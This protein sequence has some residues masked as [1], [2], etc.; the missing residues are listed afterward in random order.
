MSQS[1]RG[2]STTW[3]TDTLFVKEKSLVG[4]ICAQMFTDAEGFVYVHLMKLKSLTGEALNK[5]TLDVGVHNCIISDGTKE[6]SGDNTDFVK[7]NEA[8]SH[9]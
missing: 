6:E 8:L 7:N 2:L 1:L 9:R 4:N 3:Y 5:I